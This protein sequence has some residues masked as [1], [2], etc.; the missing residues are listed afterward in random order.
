MTH[1]GETAQW[2]LV[3]VPEEEERNMTEVGRCSEGPRRG[4]M[5]HGEGPRG[6]NITGRGLAAH[7]V[8]HVVVVPA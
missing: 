3:G 5:V 4:A 7:E 6:G 8:D 2:C 1:D